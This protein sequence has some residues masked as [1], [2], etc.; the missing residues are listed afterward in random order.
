MKKKT[1]NILTT[2]FG[3]LFGSIDIGLYVS[4]RVGLIEYDMGIVEI[5]VMAA[6]AYMLIQAYN[7]AL[8]G[9]ANKMLGLKKD[10]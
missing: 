10:G 7:P 9:F 4:S 3:L 6:L 8:Q 2:V 5:L 1:K